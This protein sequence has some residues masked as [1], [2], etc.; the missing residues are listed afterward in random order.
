MTRAVG[1]F[2][3]KAYEEN[4]TGM[5]AMV[6]YNLL[7]SLFPLALIALYIAGHVLSSPEVQIS[8]VADLQQVFPSETE[9]TL[10]DVLRRVRESSTTVGIAAIAASLWIGASFWGALDTAFC[11]IYHRTCR[12]W[13]RQK[14][15]ALGM[16]V[17]VLLFFGATVAV[18]TLQGLLVTASRD[19]PLGLD[20]VR[21]LVG[22]V[23]LA[24]GL[25]LLF[26]VLCVIYW[27]VPRG[28]VPWTAIWPGALG[29]TIGM[30]VVDYAF[31]LYLSNVSTL[32][33]GTTFVFILIV[34]IWFYV[35]ALILLAGAVVNELRFEHRNPTG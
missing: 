34:L 11:R 14:L 20:R 19:L 29:A 18:P 15:F 25:V 6:A 28:K 26:A 32:R 16:I 35:L 5:A 22:A 21:G 1:S 33:V 30:A 10:L 2:W 8:V 7:L 12:S 24:A 3:R 13:V 31:P 23:S 27:R 17:V 9:A 4:V